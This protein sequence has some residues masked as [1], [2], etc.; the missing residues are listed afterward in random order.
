MPRTVADQ[1]RFWRHAGTGIELLKARFGGHAYDR[2]AHGTY[3]IGV[4]LFGRQGF[5][6][7]GRQH[8][9]TAGTIIAMNPDDAHD[10]GAVDDGGFGYWMLYPD[11]GLWRDLLADAGAGPAGQPFF[12][13][14]LI[15]DPDCARRLLRLC[16]LLTAGPAAAL[17]AE[18]AAGDAL[19]ALAQRHGRSAPAAG[20]GPGPA[21]RRIRDLLHDGYGG[22]IR[23]DDL[24][25]EAGCSR[26]RVSRAFAAAYGLP[27]HA[28][29]TR[30][31]LE[32]ARRLL[33]GG[34]PAAEVAAAVGFV[35]QS[36]LIRRFKASY[37][38]TP[39]EFQ[40]A[41]RLSNPGGGRAR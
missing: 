37:G 20:P 35:D 41:A 16:A 10:G 17:A 26:F 3:A 23:L 22:E 29:L 38:I 30:R 34:E 31:R 13:D 18:S 4:T 24:A 14:T 15:R 11:A 28:Y 19:L 7:R 9:S 32:A 25:R 12:A 6:H 39:G 8:V 40:A 33:A 1:V 27:P 5:R 2:H 21:L 36:H